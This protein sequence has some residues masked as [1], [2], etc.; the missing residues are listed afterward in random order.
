MSIIVETPFQNFT[1]LDGKPLTNGKVYIGQVGTD[2][3]VFA[4]QIPVFWDEALTI[5][6]SQPLTTN[7]GYIVRFGTPARVYTAINYSI[8]VKNASNILVYYIADFGAIDPATQQDLDALSSALQL[9]DYAALRAYNGPRKAVYVSGYMAS[10]IPSGIAGEFVAAPGDVGSADN[11]GT[12]IVSSGGMRWKRVFNGAIDIDW[13]GAFGATDSKPAVQ[14]AISA[15]ETMGGGFLTARAG[16]TYMM[17][18][19]L[20]WNSCLVGF[21]LNGC[22][23][24]FSAMA[25]GFALLPHQTG[26]EINS[27]T[28]A[29]QVHAWSHGTLVGPG[30]PVSTVC[31]LKIEQLDDLVNAGN[32]FKNIRFQKFAVDIQ[33]GAGAFFSTFQTCVFQGTPGAGIDAVYSI[34]APDVANAGEKNT[35][36]DCFFGG[37][38]YGFDQACPIADTTFDNCRFDT[39]GE[40]AVR[41]SA[42]TCIVSAPHIEISNDTSHWFQCSGTDST[43]YIVNAPN[44]VIPSTKNVYSPFYSDVTCTNGGV[45]IDGLK[46]VFGQPISTFLIAGLGRTDGRNIQWGNSGSKPIISVY[47]NLFTY[48]GFESANFAADWSLA[49]GGG[50]APIRSTD[51]TP[52]TGTYTLKFPGTVGFTPSAVATFPCTAGQYGSVK[53]FYLTINI[54]GTG[55]NF[56]ATIDYI[57]RLGNIL[58]GGG[59]QI[60]SVTSNVGTWTQVSASQNTPAPPGTHSFRVSISL[61]GTTSGSPSGYIDDIYATIC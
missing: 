51:V 46:C 1:G 41:V 42:G 32:T 3:T 16:A 21:D 28:G 5:P 25:T 30:Y 33:F 53:F 26:I 49:G 44:L 20:Q 61:F 23:L 11:G 50:S 27:R 31:A 4:N 36:R 8:S 10:S 24:D 29:A 37:R 6:A 56:Y 38:N 35:F 52:Y 19:G 54:A 7:A 48:G 2:P 13:F 43:L 12:I 39:F 40:V 18:S 45:I 60:M 15:V 57:D 34:Q 17:G 22:T 59:A 58:P 9:P 55:G 14:S 47:Q